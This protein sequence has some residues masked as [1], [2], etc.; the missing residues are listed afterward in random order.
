M[1]ELIF[2]SR[3]AYF[4][5]VSF[6]LTDKFLGNRRRSGKRNTLVAENS[7]WKKEE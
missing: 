7:K 1:K 5:C 6:S 2:I 3:H 4:P